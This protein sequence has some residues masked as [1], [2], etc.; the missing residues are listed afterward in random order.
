MK[1]SKIIAQLLNSNIKKIKS[2][3]SLHKYTWDSMAMISLISLIEKKSKKKID[4][5]KIRDL[6]KV[7]D[8]DKFLSIYL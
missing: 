4:V 3:D 6:A 8:L 5:Q 1:N 2:S 7:M